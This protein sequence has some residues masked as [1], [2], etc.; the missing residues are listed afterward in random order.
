MLS[1]LT[2]GQAAAGAI[3]LALIVAAAV[4]AA[5]GHSDATINEL[6]APVVGAVVG[7]HLALA[8]PSGGSG[9]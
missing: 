8:V 2:S 9:K 6:V 3:A 7:G 1:Y 5:T 4:L